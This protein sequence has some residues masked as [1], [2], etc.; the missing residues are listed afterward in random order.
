MLK[1]QVSL[2]IVLYSLMT[3]VITTLCLDYITKRV[4]LYLMLALSLE[5]ENE[6]ID[7]QEL[8]SAVEPYG[9]LDFLHSSTTFLTDI[10]GN[11]YVVKQIKLLSDSDVYNLA[12]L[13]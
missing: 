6:N 11:K 9:T 13:V 1:T 7:C 2:L 12:R 4:A 10:S 3:G 5:K 8:V